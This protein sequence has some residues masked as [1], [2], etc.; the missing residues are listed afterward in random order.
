MESPHRSYYCCSSSSATER[1]AASPQ[2]CVVGSVAASLRAPCNGRRRADLSRQWLSLLHCRCYSCR[3]LP[4]FDSIARPPSAS[5]CPPR[6]RLTLWVAGRGRSVWLGLI[7][8]LAPSASASHALQSH[9]HAGERCSSHT[10]TPMTCARLSPP[11]STHNRTHHHPTQH[12]RCQ[13]LQTR[14]HGTFVARRVLSIDGW[15]AASRVLPL[16]RERSDT[17]PYSPHHPHPNKTTP[18]HHSRS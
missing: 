2:V 1:P 11:K 4:R 15:R 9:T 5:S 16:P 17:P 7:T 13:S 18:N 12:R 10:H 3:T 14:N 8:A 6:S